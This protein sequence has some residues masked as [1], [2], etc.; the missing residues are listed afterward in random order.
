MIF[1]INKL[2]VIIL[3]NEFFKETIEF[4]FFKPLCLKGLLFK[5]NNANFAL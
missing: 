1:F 2:L 4:R 5:K 3:H